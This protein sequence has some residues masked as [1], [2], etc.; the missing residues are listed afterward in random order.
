MRW[1]SM[2]ELSVNMLLLPASQ[3]HK[4]S[5]FTRECGVNVKTLKF[6]K[7]HRAAASSALF[8][9]RSRG[10]QPLCNVT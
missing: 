3:M 8:Q 6:S 7:P 9:T 5:A 10:L 1:C 2:L 4:C